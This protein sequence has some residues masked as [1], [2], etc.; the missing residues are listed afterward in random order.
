MLDL[1]FFILFCVMAVRI[2]LSVFRESAILREFNQSRVLAG[3]VFLFPLGSLVLLAGVARWGVF[4]AFPLAAACYIPG[5]M[6]AHRLSI[7]LERTGT[8]R[9]KG[10]R[11]VASQ[12]FGTALVGLAYVVAV[13]VLAFAISVV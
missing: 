13:A 4:V 7:A 9:V 12:A 8:D 1:A 10:I 11:N 5:L 3:V 2:A 6:V